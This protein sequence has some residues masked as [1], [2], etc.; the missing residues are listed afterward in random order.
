MTVVFESADVTVAHDAGDGGQRCVVTF[1]SLNVHTHGFGDAFFARHG[2]TAYHFVAKWNHWWQPASLRDA[3]RAVEKALRGAGRRPAMTY[4]SSM[5]AYGAALYARELGARNVLMLAPQWSANPATPPHEE[6]WSAEARRID[7]M[8]DDM[9]A[10]ICRDAR[11]YVVFDPAGPDA[12]HAAFFA[13]IPA[14]TLL[15]CV[16]GGHVIAHTLQQA[17]LLTDLVFGAMDGSLDAVGWRALWS[18]KRRQAGRFWYELGLRAARHGRPD[19]SLRCLEQATTLRPSEATFQLDYGY[20]LLRRKQTE[21]AIEVF[22]TASALAP[23]QP[24]PWRALSVA[25][26]AQGALRQAISAG[27]QALALRGTSA[28][29]RRILVQALLE[30]G[31]YGRAVE[32]ILPAVE[33]EP[34]HAESRRLLERARGGLQADRGRPAG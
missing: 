25:W 24:A 21:R 23:D 1:S 12:R 8:H 20:A 19:L 32:V 15:R 9:A 30:A 18:G 29:L 31:E 11:K 4:G 16:D 5:G 13:T 10:H 34:G 26:R 27:E 3:V 7:F 22:K 14:T 33:A 17:G 6:R 2:V 28:D